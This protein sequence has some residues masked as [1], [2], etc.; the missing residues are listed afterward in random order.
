MTPVHFTITKETPSPSLKIVKGTRQGLALPR[1]ENR[2]ILH[3]FY[4]V[5]GAVGAASGVGSGAGVSSA[6]GDS[7]GTPEE[8]PPACGEP[9]ESVVAADAVHYPPPQLMPQPAPCALRG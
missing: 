9:V 7:S 4:W 5:A 2:T 3:I 1:P 6:G 8:S